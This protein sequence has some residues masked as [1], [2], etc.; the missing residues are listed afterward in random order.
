M[1]SSRLSITAKGFMPHL[2]DLLLF[3]DRG[4]VRALWR[5]GMFLGGSAVVLVGL[6]L[7]LPSSDHGSMISIFLIAL[8]SGGVFAV[9]ALL[10]RF[11][12]H[13]P[14]AAL[15]LSFDS[16]L[17]IELLQ[18]VGG[19]LA[20][21]TF[22]L[23]VQWS[24][25]WVSVEIEP[26]V[27]GDRLTL[28][29]GA[30]LLL[31]GAACLEELLFRG[32]ALQVLV[33]LSGAAPAVVLSSVLFGLA[34][35]SNPNA[36]WLS[37]ANTTLAGVLLAVVY[38]RSRSLWLPMALHF[39]WNFCQ[40]TLYGLP[41]SGIELDTPLLRSQLTASGRQ[42]A[43]VSGGA[44]GPEGGLVLTVGVLALLVVALRCSCVRPAP[45]ALALWMEPAADEPPG[46]ED[47][48]PV[49]GGLDREEEAR[50]PG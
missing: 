27:N 30:V 12:E 3:D 50:P 43:W 45:G 25:G 44:Y 32:Y 33:Q 22:V 49:D 29:G 1:A 47:S 10:V 31:V 38:L 13:R 19:G 2:L 24:A 20:L 41:V 6:S 14:L 9:A 5:I 40:G 7:V 18:G 46:G 48:S 37:L 39:S 8:G 23:L 36:D 11:V 4:R 21:M 16:R 34:H 26:L 42:L 28:V 15:G 35:N 17:R